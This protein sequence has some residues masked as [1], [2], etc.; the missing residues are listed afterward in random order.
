MTRCLIGVVVAVFS[1]ADA[2]MAEI[3]DNAGLIVQTELVDFLKE[4]GIVADEAISIPAYKRQY[5]SQDGSV[6]WEE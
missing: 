1:V 3:D 5:L 4:H 6:Q 2:A